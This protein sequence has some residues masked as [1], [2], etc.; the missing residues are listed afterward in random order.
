MCA[1]VVGLPDER[2]GDL[3]IACVEL[4]PGASLTMDDLREYFAGRGITRKFWPTGIHLVGKW[5]IGPTG[6]TDRRMLLAAYRDAA[7]GG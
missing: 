7:G 6:K 1:L 2:L 3:P 4:R 5:P